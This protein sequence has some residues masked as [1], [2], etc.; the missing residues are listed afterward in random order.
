MISKPILLVALLI[1][2]TIDHFCLDVL[3]VPYRMVT[4]FAL[5]VILYNVLVYLCNQSAILRYLRWVGDPSAKDIGYDHLQYDDGILHHR[6]YI[7][8]FSKKVI[9]REWEIHTTPRGKQEI[10][11]ERLRS[12]APSFIGLKHNILFVKPEY[13]GD[14]MYQGN[15]IEVYSIF[16]ELVIYAYAID[17][18]LIRYTGNPSVFSPECIEEYAMTKNFVDIKKPLQF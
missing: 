8:M 9:H 6:V 16:G 15:N 5:V 11:H 7:S 13:L 18:E 10:F 17:G 2:L 4:T 1:S 12:T 14:C 3:I